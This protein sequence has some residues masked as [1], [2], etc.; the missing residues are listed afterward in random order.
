VHGAG[1]TVHVENLVAELGAD[2]PARLQHLPAA[3][4]AGLGQRYLS[5][6]SERVPAQS[7]GLARITD[8]MPYNFLH[9]GLIHAMFPRA[10]IVHCMRNPLDTCLSCYV[11]LFSKGHEFSYDLTELGRYYRA[12]AELMAHWRSVVPANRLLEVTYENVV[13]DL[14]GEARR[15]IGFCGLP[16]DEACLRFHESARPVRTASL[17]Q[18]RQPLYRGS[19]G[20]AKLFDSGLAALREALGDLA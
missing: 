9:V 10:R 16:W 17:H 14:A 5:A 1:E 6:V 13:D 15:L 11:T 7:Q 20:R 18:V 12:Y 2:Y 8:K 3:Q 19:V 4:I